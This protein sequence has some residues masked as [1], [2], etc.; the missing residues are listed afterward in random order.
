MFRWL[1]TIQ[2]S[3][4]FTIVLVVN[5][6]Y[7]SAAENQYCAAKDFIEVCLEQ[8]QSG[9][10]IGKRVAAAGWN[11]RYSEPNYVGLTKL[12]NPAISFSISE[13]TFSDSFTQSCT[14]DYWKLISTGTKAYCSGEEL[15]TIDTWIAAEKGELVADN[16]SPNPQFPNFTKRGLTKVWKLERGLARMSVKLGADEFDQGKPLV[17]HILSI[18]RMFL[19]ARSDE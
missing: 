15:A 18:E 3:M 11:V 1:S 7:V 19:T 5:S 16:R 6:V 13:T 12:S 2:L 14:F 9:V 4:V 8:D 17:T 10:A